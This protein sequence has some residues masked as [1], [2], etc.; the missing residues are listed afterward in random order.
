M[1]ANRFTIEISFLRHPRRAFGIVD[2]SS[3]NELLLVLRGQVFFPCLSRNFYL[4]RPRCEARHRDST[5]GEGSWKFS[6]PVSYGVKKVENVVED[7]KGVRVKGWFI[8]R[9]EEPGDRC[10]EINIIHALL[11]VPFHPEVSCIS[12]LAIQFLTRSL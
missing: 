5:K 11:F 7:H 9:R 3:R 1:A 10:A 6:R 2:C 12:W 8:V 4:R